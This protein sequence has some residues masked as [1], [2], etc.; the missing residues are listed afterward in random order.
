MTSTSGQKPD[1]LDRLSDPGLSQQT[2]KVTS[3]QPGLASTSK[4]CHGTKT[5]AR[6]TDRLHSF[7]R[8]F[9]KP[10]LYSR[11]SL[12]TSNEPDP[13]Y[14][15]VTDHYHSSLNQSGS[16][17]LAEMPST[18]TMCSQTSTQYP[19]MSRSQSR[20]ENRLKCY[21]GPRSQPNQSRPMEIGSLPGI[22]WLTP[23]CS[24]SST[25]D[26]NSS[27]TGNISRGISLPYLPNSTPKSSIMT[28]LCESEHHNDVTLSYPACQSSPTC[29]Y[30]GFM[31]QSTRHL[32]HLQTPER[33]K[34]L[35]VVEALPEKDGMTVDAPI[36]P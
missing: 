9:R 30:N 1:L 18:S 21:M 20:S 27:C 7:P 22:P 32:H 19:V 2:V 23:H 17:Y 26:L 25:R 13:H 6:K 36:Q 33:N 10:T 8:L 29:K 14:S 24:S 16:T 28:E 3:T 11:I 4:P 15:T 35:T 12:G 34:P 31:A 5:Q